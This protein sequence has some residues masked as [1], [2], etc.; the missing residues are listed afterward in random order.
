MQLSLIT[1]LEL[2]LFKILAFCLPFSV[3]ID[4][5]GESRIHFPTEILIG[6]LA[7]LLA[8]DLLK[9]Y[10]VLKSEYPGEL[11]WIVPLVAAYILFI[12]FSEMPEVSAKFSLVNIIYILIFYVL[13]VRLFKLDQGLFPQLLLIYSLGLIAVTGWAIFR[14]HTFEWNPVVVPGIFRPFYRDHTIL[15]ASAA[16]LAVFWLCFSFMTKMAVSRFVSVALAIFFLLLVIFSGSRAAFFSLFISLSVGVLFLLRFRTRHVL[17]LLFSLLL[18]AFFFGG[19]IREKL[20][21]NLAESRNPNAGY[22]EHF[23]SAGNIS[24]DA[25]NLERMNRWVAAW[26]M[27][28]ARPLTGFG[29][30]TYQFTY[31]PF[32]EESLKTHLSVED[33][34]D[35]PENSGGT[36]HSEYLLVL[37]EM[38][39]LGFVALILFFGRL[40]YVVFDKSYGHNQ[41]IKIMVAFSALAGYWFHALFN[42]F[43]NTEKFAFLF[44]GM[45]AW[46]IANY[47][48]TDEKGILPGS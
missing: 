30:G 37:S 28:T 20:L 36:A 22:V 12:L 18:T 8:I 17:L 11:L 19:T 47:Y 38:G 4:I 3:E 14:Y 21:D 16:L 15:G 7:V 6:L 13:Q 25:S 44:W 29:P 23:R 46:L 1:R 31:I 24:T 41:K 43:L 26:R 34:L 9:N 2:F 45:A 33:P 32:Q 5:A 39:I 35:I 27:F 48:D 40:M 42:N 10:S